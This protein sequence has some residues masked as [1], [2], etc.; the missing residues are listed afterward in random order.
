MANV[1]LNQK[2]VETLSTNKES[3]IFWDD[4]FPRGGS[5]GLRVFKSGKRSFLF[6]YRTKA[7]VKRFVTIGDARLLRL[8]KAREEALRFVVRV[9]NGEDPSGEKQEY[10]DSETV[11]EIV[12]DFRAIYYKE[13]KLAPLTIKSYDQLL[14]SRILPALGDRKIWDISK[15][16]V[17]KFMDGIKKEGRLQAARN[18]QTLLTTIFNFAKSRGVKTQEPCLGLAKPEGGRRTR[19]LH[20]VEIGKLWNVLGEEEQPLQGLFKL[21]LLTGQRSEEIRSAK[22]SHIKDGKWTFPQTKSQVEQVIPVT[23]LMASVLEDLRIAHDKR[24]RT[25]R[26]ALKD[27]MALYLFPS[28]RAKQTDGK[29]YIRQLKVPC[30]KIAAKVIGSEDA[31]R[32]TPH[33]L[34]RTLVTTLRSLGVS[35][36][37]VQRILNHA[38][39]RLDSRS[40]L[41][42]Y[43]RFDMFDNVAEALVKF[44]DEVLRL[45]AL[46]KEKRG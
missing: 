44:G 10:R 36:S 30:E 6:G 39:S 13:R 45:A 22:W 23:P 32:F 37:V 3:E 21:L 14:T 46:Y 17:V 2:L 40:L 19:Y 35:K 24:I 38:E 16:D 1:T 20:P 34:R 33:D 29:V 26:S 8:T 5:F 12:E 42:V 15:K 43:D 28:R 11:A 27:E 7:G 18:T 41:S 31:T 9:Q 25:T 4:N